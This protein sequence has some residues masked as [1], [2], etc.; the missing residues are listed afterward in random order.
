MSAP[1]PIHFGVLFGSPLFTLNSRLEPRSRG[2]IAILVYHVPLYSSCSFMKHFGRLSNQD[3]LVLYKL[4]LCESQYTY[5]LH[6]SENVGQ[7]Y[8]SAGRQRTHS[9]YS[10]RLTINGTRAPSS[11]ATFGRSKIDRWLPNFVEGPS[12]NS[13]V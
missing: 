4:T 13:N 7:Q 3:T 10:T 6:Q 2:D 9:I 5:R 8:E 11:P 1:S 12:G